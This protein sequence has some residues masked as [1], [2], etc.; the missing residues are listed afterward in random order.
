MNFRINQSKILFTGKVFNLKVDEIEY[1]KTHNLAVREVVIHKG[2]AVILAVTNENKI[3]MVNQFRYPFQKY[4]LELPAGKLDPDENPQQCAARELTEETGFIVGKI[5]KLGSIYTSPGYSSEELQIFLA[6]GLSFD[7]PN[8]EEG[9]EG[10]EV[11]QLTL[12]EID[13]KIKK[14][15]I[16]DAKTISGLYFYKTLLLNN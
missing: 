5:Q 13:N 3:I 14:G 11:F 12:N 10:M 16:I 4:L 9:E 8:R 2:G 1:N 15:E 7:K 6:T